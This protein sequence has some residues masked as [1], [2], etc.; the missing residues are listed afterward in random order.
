MPDVDFASDYGTQF[1]R[2]SFPQSF[3]CERMEKTP[4]REHPTG[5][6]GSAR[7]AN[8]EPASDSDAVRNRNRRQ[9]S[10]VRADAADGEQSVVP[11]GSVSVMAHPGS[12]V[13]HE[14]PRN[15]KIFSRKHESM[16]GFF[17]QRQI[18]CLNEL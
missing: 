1:S 15:S 12:S 8:D 9:C 5:R 7:S 17:F 16:I 2:Y 13:L 14:K 3:V 10:S 11:V 18:K 4:G 6:N